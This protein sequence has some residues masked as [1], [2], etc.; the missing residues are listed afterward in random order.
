MYN[1][2]DLTLLTSLAAQ[3]LG[4]PVRSATLTV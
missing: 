3:R 1:L 4:S 2:H